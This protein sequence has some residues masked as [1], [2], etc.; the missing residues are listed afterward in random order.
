MAQAISIPVPKTQAR[1]KPIKLIIIVGQVI[2]MVEF[3][4]NKTKG[5]A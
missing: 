4:N 2:K 1:I 5:G 3:V